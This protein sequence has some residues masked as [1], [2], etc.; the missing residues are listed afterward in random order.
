[1]KKRTGPEATATAVG[2]F[3]TCMTHIVCGILSKDNIATFKPVTARGLHF[4]K[5]PKM[6]A[7]CFSWNKLTH[8][9]R[10]IAKLDISYFCSRNVSTLFRCNSSVSNVTSSQMSEKENTTDPILKIFKITEL[11]AFLNFQANRTFGKIF[12]KT[13]RIWL[14]RIS[15]ALSCF[16]ILWHSTKELL[17]KRYQLN[18]VGTFHPNNRIKTPIQFWHENISYIRSRSTKYELFLL[19]ITQVLEGCS[20]GIHTI[21]IKDIKRKNLILKEKITIWYQK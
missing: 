14:W 1:M 11:F 18:K 19:F 15:S 4:L 16:C 7:F 17:D 13:Q 12:K 8:L 10:N 2:T 9:F 3:L 5:T 20:S 6:Y 21:H